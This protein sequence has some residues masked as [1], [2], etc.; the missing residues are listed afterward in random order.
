MQYMWQEY[1]TSETPYTNNDIRTA[2][3]EV[4]GSERFA[5]NFFARYIDDSQLP[6][7]GSLLANA[8]LILELANPGEA[9]AGPVS[10]FFDGKAAFISENT[11]IGTPL[12]TAGLDRGDQVVAID[13]LSISS[14]QRWIDALERYEPGDTATIHYVQRGIERTAEITFVEDP[15]L[16]VVTVE[17]TGEDLGSDASRFREA[18]LGSQVD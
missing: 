2:L 13:R 7:Y 1:G 4:T 10:F 16:Q 8:G 18:W 15:Q 17:S 11:V 12:Y 6:D 9:S 5:T 3:I 14:Q